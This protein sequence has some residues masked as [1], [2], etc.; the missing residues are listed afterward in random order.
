M[1]SSASACL[2]AVKYLLVATTWVLF[3][4]Y[5]L[6]WVVLEPELQLQLQTFKGMAFVLITTAVL[7][8]TARHQLR[9]RRQQELALRKNDERFN[10]ALAGGNDG[11]W[12]WDLV[13]DAF[14]LSA[15]CRELLGIT[16]ERPEGIAQQWLE[17]LHPDDKEP[18]RA[19]FIAHLRGKTER[20]ELTYRVV[21]QHADLVWVQVSGQAVRNQQGRALRLV[22]ILRDISEQVRREQRLLQAGVMFD[23]TSEGMLICD[24][25]QN[26]ID[27]NNAFC[28]ITGYQ[29]VDVIGRSPNLLAS[30]RHDT[31]F[32]RRMWQQIIATGRWSGEIWNRRKDG[33]IYPQWQNIIA[34][35]DHMGTLTHYVAVF[36]DISMIKR[37]QQEIDYLAHHD[38]LTKLPNRLLFN[39][40]LNTAIVRA[41]RHIT[42]LGLIF[43]DLDRFKGI[44]DSL[45]HSL[46]DEMLQRVAERV[47]Q[48]CEDADTLSRLSGDEFAL[49]VERPVGFDDLSKLAERI[50]QLLLEP[51]EL[52]GQLIHMTASIGLS[53]FPSDGNDGAELLKNADSAVSLAKS[54]GRNSYAFYTQELTEQARRRMN[55]ET[56][57]HLALQQHQLRVYYQLQKD[58]RS[59]QWIGMEA[60]VRWEH[61]EHGV[62]PPDEFLPVARHAGLMG[63][64][65]EFVLHQAC[66]QMRQWLDAGYPLRTMAVNMSGYWMER[67]DVLSSARSALANSNLDAHYLELEVTEDEVMHYG[68]LS[69]SLLDQLSELGVR[70]AID[71]FGTGYSSLLRLKRMP[72]NKL[73]IDRGFI[74]DLPGSESDSAMARTIIGLGKSL[75]LTTI[76]EGIETQAQEDLLREFGCDA[77]QGYLYNQPLPAVEVEKILMAVEL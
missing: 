45:G 49:L 46:G 75:Q 26:I 2:I 14:Y 59:G 13:A 54:R 33:E 61:P 69:V 42:T 53:L 64:I 22:G 24:A 11:V 6:T 18:L 28:Q 55:L 27:V 43:I 76:A 65:D 68:D 40:R 44:N 50:Q 57:L 67:G 41:S 39:E 8:F 29:P 38:P 31:E 17:Y 7:F 47:Q 9:G 35:K 10:L 37:S 51:F 63:E 60:L 30:G 12:D 74:S 32:Y 71:D 20:L 4:D 66:A 62:I 15:R 48:V 16:A 21:G 72:V 23:C 3:S 36:A 52:N 77:G 73:K 34:V 5:L 56:E 70:L 19:A 1:S 25:E 58:L